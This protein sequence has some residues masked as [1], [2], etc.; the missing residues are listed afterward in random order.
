MAPAGLRV[1]QFAVL[2]TVARAG[3]AKISELAQWLSLD[4]TA[5]RRNL[6]PLELKGLVRV[7]A[8]R[9]ARVREVTLTIAGREAIAAAVPYWEHGQELV[10]GRLGERKMTT[11]LSALDELEA[12][13]RPAREA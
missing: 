8:G 4:R 5:L 3:S 6:Q 2:R 12:I 7:A 10:A 11:L 1:T 9:D 13:A